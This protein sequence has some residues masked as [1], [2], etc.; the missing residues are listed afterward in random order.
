MS[1]IV[2]LRVGR[3]SLWA[4]TRYMI[5]A[6]IAVLVLYNLVAAA[7]ILFD[8]PWIGPKSYD[9]DGLSYLYAHIGVAVLPVLYLAALRCI[10]RQGGKA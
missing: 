3:S 10:P 8:R 2:K 9:G 1:D 6:P 4:V 5:F 7:S